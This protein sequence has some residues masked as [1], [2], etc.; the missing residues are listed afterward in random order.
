MPEFETL[1]DEYKFTDI[2]QELDSF[3]LDTI[4]SFNG[5]VDL[6]SN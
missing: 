6:I 2:D 4:E 3:Y 5:D 1:L